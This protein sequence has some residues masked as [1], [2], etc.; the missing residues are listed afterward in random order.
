M[1]RLFPH[2]TRELF[3]KEDTDCL[4]G[5]MMLLVIALHLL[6]LLEQRYDIT[7]AYI[8]WKNWGSMA[9]GT[10]LFI[11]GY[12]LFYS[13]DKKQTVSYKY[14][15]SKFNKL[16]IPFVFAFT[17]GALICTSIN[18]WQFNIKDFITLTIPMT[19]SW[20]IKFII[21]TFVITLIIYKI[22]GCKKTILLLFSLSL[23]YI[24]ICK[25]H[26]LGA[27]WYNSS[28]CFPLGALA[29]KLKRIIPP[30][31]LLFICLIISLLLLMRGTSSSI[32]NAIMFSSSTVV[33]ISF[34]NIRNNVLRY[35]GLKSYHFYVFHI[36][37]YIPYSIIFDN[38]CIYC[39]SVVITTIVCVVIYNLIIDKSNILNFKTGILRS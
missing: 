30:P 18:S 17:V 27:Q 14:I 7:I 2:T 25:T 31:P 12:G 5:I 36:S 6:F 32:I 23:I 37:C 26:G 28:L 13:L 3:L 15:L 24:Y 1:N 21:A 19:A 10:F 35:I 34:I 39:L 11:T 38:A 20:F 16:Y 29:F 33:V 22:F 8:N 9:V 4:K